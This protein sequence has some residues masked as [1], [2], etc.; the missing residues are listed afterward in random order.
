[1]SFF[2]LQPHSQRECPPLQ[3]NRE[4]TRKPSSRRRLTAA[5]LCCGET[6]IRNLNETYYKRILEV[7]DC[8]AISRTFNKKY[9]PTPVY[10]RRY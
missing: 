10:L 3:L 1:M 8:C 4:I 9:V 2:D 6:R 5:F 7:C